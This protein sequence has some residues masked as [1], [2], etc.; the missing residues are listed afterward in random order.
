LHSKDLYPKVVVTDRDN[1]LINAVEKVF[2]DATTLLCSYHIGQNVREKCYLDCKVKDLKG[3]DGEEFNHGSVVK[4]VMAAWMDI[5]DSETE[6]AYIDNWNQFK[7]VY[8]KFPKFLEYV[9]KTI[10]DPVKDKVVKFWVDK[11]I[12]MGN[13][14]TNRAESAHARLKKYLSSSMGDLSTN[15]KSVHDMLELQHTTIH[16]SF[17]TRIIMLEHRFKGKV[18]W[19]RL[20]QNISREDL[21]HLVEEYNKT[22][23][24]GT[25]KSRCGCLNLITHRLPCA[26]MIALKIKNSSALRLDEIHTH[27][28]RL[29]FEYEVDPKLYKADTSLL[30]K[31]D[32]LKVFF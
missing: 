29:R 27:L 26:R 16:A 31:W 9:E 28:K 13:T 32:I 23:E 10:L 7:V 24:I 11:A 30:P 4:T 15:W 18:L 21:H 6:E 25:D 20:I 2:P 12:H 22:L 14:T 3:K 17:Q 1:A 19:S 8:G 5:V